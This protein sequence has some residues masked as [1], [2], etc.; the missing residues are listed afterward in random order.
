[1]D[2]VLPNISSSFVG[3]EEVSTPVINKNNLIRWMNMNE[4]C[5]VEY[6]VFATDLSDASFDIFIS[7]IFKNY[8]H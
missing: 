4:S 8:I 1:M 3:W 2:V 5:S 6:N 7:K